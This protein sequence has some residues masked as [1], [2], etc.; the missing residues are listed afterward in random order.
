[1]WPVIAHGAFSD[2][3]N[4]YEFQANETY[5]ANIRVRQN[6]DGRAVVYSGEDA[7]NEYI[8]KFV[9]RDRFDPSNPSGN[10]DL[11]DHGTL[12]VARFDADGTGTWLPLVHG[13]NGLTAE[14]FDAATLRM[15]LATV[16]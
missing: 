9:S 15:T 16:G 10:R 13:E 7:R 6:Q 3:D 5:K 1:M 2:H 14:S 11:L 8:Y 12:H 4:E